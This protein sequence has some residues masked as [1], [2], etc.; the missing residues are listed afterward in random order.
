MSAMKV[1]TEFRELMGKG[2]REKAFELIDKDAIWNS[3]E[4]GAPWS[5]IHKGIT[6][7]TKHFEAVSGTTKQFK[8]NI[9]QLFEKENLVIEIGSLSC[10]LNKTN[11]PFETEYVCVYKVNNGKITYYRIYEDSLKL[12]KAY[13]E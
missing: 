7:I 12:Y 10:I 13:Y 8:R 1:I 6:A 11:K 3:D 2:D 5:G 4:I 9:D